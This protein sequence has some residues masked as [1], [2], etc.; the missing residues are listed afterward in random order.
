MFIDRAEIRVQ[1]GKGGDGAVA[2]RREKFEPSG[3]PAGG[4]GGDGGDIILKVDEG[5]GTLM[6]FRYKRVYKGNNGENGRSKNQFG[7][8]GEDIIIKVP[9]GTLIKDKNSGNVIVDLKDKD[10]SYTIV[11]GGKGGKGNSRFATSTRQAPKFAEPGEK[12]EER[13]IILELKLLADAG[14]VG[15]PNVGKSTILSILSAARPKIANYHF[16]TLS[17][18]LGV[19]RVG[20][21]ESFVLADIPGLIE[22]AAEGVGL[23]HE[24]LRHIERTRILIHVLDISGIEGRDPLEDL[25]TINEELAGYNPKL[26]DK[27]QLI[28]ANKIDLPGGEENLAE[29][30]DKLG[31]KNIKIVETSAATKKGI[32]QL[33]YAIWEL[34][35]Q[36]KEE[37]KTLDKKHVEEVVKEERIIVKKEDGKYI[38]EG[39]LIEELLRATHFDNVDSL[40]YFQTVL[41]RE[42]I[43]EELEELGIQEGETVY[44]LDYEFEFIP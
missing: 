17:P 28:V 34:L 32:D 5:I 8:M 19:V 29:L 15:F 13:E 14:L 20:E 23:G 36:T 7:K 9:K 21:G 44:I 33:K 41:R 30:K 31:G 10:Q 24:F 12:G 43:I 1:A 40:R 11:K 38:V 4:D 22:G 35:S 39:S 26:K 16:T 42:G 3:G 25:S 6:D 18:N 2:W 37:Y 27:P